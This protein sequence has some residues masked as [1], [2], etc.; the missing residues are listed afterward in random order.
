LSN[1]TEVAAAA[2]AHTSGVHATE[3]LLF[4]VLLQLTLIVLAGRAGSALA[5][6]WGQSSAVGEIIVGILLGPSLFGLLFPEVFTYVF[7]SVPPGPMTMF[8][9]VGLLLLMSQIGL[10]F[11][12]AHLTNAQPARGRGVSVATLVL[13]FG[14]RLRFGSR[15]DT[16]PLAR[17]RHPCPSLFIVT[18]F[19]ITAL[20]IPGAS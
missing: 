6:R 13:P 9:Q 2:A 18:A 4:F 7:K 1:T 20:P 5:K 8:A 16:H 15:I 12:F 14:A 17:H 3:A 19:S 11:D 10:E